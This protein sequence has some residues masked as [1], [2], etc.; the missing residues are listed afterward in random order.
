MANSTAAIFVPKQ[1]PIMVSLLISPDSLETFSQVV[2]QPL[3][4]RKTLTE[5][6]QIEKSL[7]AAIDPDLDY[8]QDIQPWLGDEITLAVTSLDFDHNRNNAAQP[9]YLLVLTTKDPEKTREFLQLYYSQQTIAGSEDLAFEQYK[10]VNLIY[11]RRS[12]KLG[13]PFADS[14][15]EGMG[16]TLTVAMVGDRFLLFANHPKVLRDAIN[17]VQVADLNLAHDPT[18]QQTLQS[19]TEPR[20]GLSFVNL[21]ALGAWVANQPTEREDG[22]LNSQ[23]LALTFSLKRQGLM[24]QA[25]IVGLQADDKNEQPT[26]SQP[27][28]ALQHIPVESSLAIAGTDLNQFWHRLSTGLANE[29]TLKFL[30]DESLA[31]LESDLSIQLPAEVFS[32]VQGEYALSLLPGKE[33]TNPDWVFVAQKTPSNETEVAIEHLDNLAQQQGLSVGNLSLDQQKITAWTKLSASTNFLPKKKR[34]VALEAKVQG[35]HA[36]VGD[37]EIFTSSIEAMDKALA[38][39]ANSLLETNQFRSAIA[40]LPQPNDG[41]LYLDWTRSKSFID[42]QLPIVRV[43]Q[44]LLKPLFNHLDSLSISSYGI[45]SGIQKSQLFIRL[46]KSNQPN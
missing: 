38:G 43:A 17:N 10:G 28:D 29:K 31:S 45:E 3:A 36:S 4:R 33:Q 24:A 30:L 25:A 18:Y 6:E 1:A 37:Y 32:W 7:L 13:I 19:L 14:E 27:V 40:P 26:L 21:P 15:L 46:D 16:K 22:L 11:K 42:Q 44:L 34:S 2:T 35:V 23:T 20:I 41:Y 5:F 39:K 12:N 8:R 9:G